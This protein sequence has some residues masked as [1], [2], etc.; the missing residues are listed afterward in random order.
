M[1]EKIAIIGAGGQSLE[2]AELIRLLPAPSYTLWGIFDDNSELH[3]KEFH[4]IKVLGP[5]AMAVEHPEVNLVNS[6][7]SLSNLAVRPNL[8]KKCGGKEDRWPALIHPSAVVS[9]SAQLAPGVIVMANGVVGA[10]ARLDFGATLLPSAVVS[11][12][13]VV[14]EHS[15]L[16]TGAIMSGYSR[17]GSLCYLGAGCLIRDG[18]TLD[19]G[20]VI[21]MG[22]VVV[23]DVPP[24]QTVVGNP[25]RPL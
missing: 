14:G 6:I 13:A 22:A 24:G 20:S 1:A 4:G 25:A 15:V 9:A 2:I 10:E 18:I 19:D 7:L 17:A 23:K 3:G 11:H 8:T 5:V 12:Q 21:G 16:A